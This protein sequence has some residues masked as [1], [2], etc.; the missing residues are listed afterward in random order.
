MKTRPTPK[1]RIVDPKALEEVRALLGT[2]FPQRDL[3]IEHLHK[4]QDRYGHL[5][6]AHLAALAAEMRLSL[7]EVYEVATFYHHFEIGRASC[8]ERV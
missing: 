3:L 2:D 4:L 8:R 6:A 7:A 5:S 1:G